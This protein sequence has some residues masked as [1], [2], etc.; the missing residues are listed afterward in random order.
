LY[1]VKYSWRGQA[2]A[3]RCNSFRNWLEAECAKLGVWSFPPGDFRQPVAVLERQM[4]LES[5]LG[6]RLQLNFFYVGPAMSSLKICDWMMWLWRAGL[7]TA[8]AT[9]RF[10]ALHT[11]F[12]KKFANGSTG[13]RDR[14]S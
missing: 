13:K 10:D 1:W 8:F 3:G 9:F 2:G 12:L 5:A 7:T 14:R 4:P 11:A 6:A